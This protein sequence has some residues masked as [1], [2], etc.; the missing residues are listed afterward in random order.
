MG[1]VFG[2]E[3]VLWLALIA[4]IVKTVS[5]FWIHVSADQQ[6]VINACVAAAV[7]LLV[8]LS[9]HDG[10]SAAILGLVQAVGALAVGFG[11]HW[12]PDQQ[13]LVMSLAT[14]LVAMFT[15]TQVTAPVSAAQATAPKIG[16]K[17]AA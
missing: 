12:A 16:A 4:V 11:L 17:A 9:T 1:K 13:A 6:S 7:G 14:A 10:V 8:A 5:A 2:R 15:R 3:P